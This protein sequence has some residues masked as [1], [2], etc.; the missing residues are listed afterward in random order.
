MKHANLTQR[1]IDCFF[2]AYN[3]LGFGLPENIYSGALEV[4]FTESGLPFRRE[5]SVDVQ[6]RNRRIGI[7]RLDYLIDDVVVVELKAGSVLPLGSKAQLITY[8]H[9]THKSTGLLLFF[10]PEP[11]VQ[12]VDLR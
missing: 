9:V 10:G 12:R 3:E 11:D 4:L 6:Y 7:F 8:L 5:H 2:V 1:V